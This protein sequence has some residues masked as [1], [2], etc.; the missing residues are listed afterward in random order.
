MSSDNEAALDGHLPW[1]EIALEEARRAAGEGEVPVGAA[2]VQDGAV[3]ATAYN[4]P[5]ALRDPTAHAEML[6]I[7]GFPRQ[8]CMSPWSRV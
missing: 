1:M 4:R 2:L 5:I 7:I 3:L 8:S 6:G